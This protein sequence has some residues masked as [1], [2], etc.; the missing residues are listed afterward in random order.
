MSIHRVYC[1][2]WANKNFIAVVCGTKR[3]NSTTVADRLMTIILAIVSKSPRSV[4]ILTKLLK[5]ALAATSIRLSIADAGSR[6]QVT[7]RPLS[8]LPVHCRAQHPLGSVIEA[9]QQ[10][11]LTFAPLCKK[12]RVQMCRFDVRTPKK[13][14]AN[15]LPVEGQTNE[16][17]RD[18]LNQVD[19]QGQGDQVLQCAFHSQ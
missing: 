18:V 3:G 9:P 6:C 15:I 10:V 17:T 14:C 1:R 4:L 11:G 19:H 8:S 2:T 12:T 7:T 13:I 5:S 16:R